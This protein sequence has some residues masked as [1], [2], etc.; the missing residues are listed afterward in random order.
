MT[1]HNHHNQEELD[2]IATVAKSVSYI[3]SL[4][5]PLAEAVLA[6]LQRFEELC[7]R[8]QIV[9]PTGL[10]RSVYEQLAREL[11]LNQKALGGAPQYLV[12]VTL[13]HGDVSDLT[14][15]PEFAFW[16]NNMSLLRHVARRHPSDPHGFLQQAERTIVKM[17][18]DSE[19]AIWR[20]MTGVIRK[21][22]VMR[23]KDPKGFLLN[24]EKVARKLECDPRFALWQDSSWVYRRT[25]LEYP[26]DPQ[27][28]LEAQ[29]AL[30]KQLMHDPD[31]AMWRST[32]WA[33]KDAVLSHPNTAKA[34]L[35][36]A[37]KTVSKLESKSMHAPTKYKPSAIKYAA[38]KN[39]GNPHRFIC[40]TESELGVKQIG[41]SPLTAQEYLA[42]LR[43]LHS[44]SRITTVEKWISTHADKNDPKIAAAISSGQICKSLKPALARELARSIESLAL[45]RRMPVPPSIRSAVYDLLARDLQANII[46]FGGKPQKLIGATLHQGNLSDLPS[47]PEATRFADTPYIVATAVKSYPRDP[48][49]F[50]R[51]AGQQIDKLK[52]DRHFAIFLENPYVFDLAVAR[53]SK[54]PEHFLQETLSIIKRISKNEYFAELHDILWVLIYAATRYRKTP[55]KFLKQFIKEFRN[56][57]LCEAGAR[58][59]DIPWLYKAA[60]LKSTEVLLRHS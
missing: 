39:S 56:S 32:P 2:R 53:H 49:A 33:Y 44:Q 55:E 43:S 15:A 21:T 14:T 1:G 17:N 35:V 30:V 52:A 48:A 4:P 58:F 8:R 54:D 50:L 31:L 5:P 12:A 57:P 51:R 29:T 10:H 28:S 3:Q 45:R 9:I 25:A 46:T 13:H 59:K 27:A 23:P 24:A 47:R 22:A 16:Q 38:L 40:P 18:A 34:F 7:R 42:A 20:D 41:S 19:L 60:I 36:R 26:K 11:V 6:L 37:A